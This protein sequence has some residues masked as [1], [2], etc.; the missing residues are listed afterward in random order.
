MWAYNYGP[1]LSHHGIR[2]MKW[3][4]R[5][6]QKSDGTLTPA[7]KKR[8]DDD[9]STNTKKTTS[10]K[11]SDSSKKKSS[12]TAVKKTSSKKSTSKKQVEKKDIDSKIASFGK[13]AAANAIRYRQNQATMRSINGLLTGDLGSYSYNSMMSR[14]YGNL[15]R[16]LF[17]DDD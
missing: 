5:R 7:G 14:S 13:L 12:K 8:Y 15:N 3:G 1:E 17:G 10:R 2:G 11:P 9:A 4:H 16:Y 6:F